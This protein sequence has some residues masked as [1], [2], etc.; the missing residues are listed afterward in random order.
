MAGV[1]VGREV[2]RELCSSLPEANRRKKSSRYGR[3]QSFC[4]KSV[5]FFFD[6]LV[7]ISRITFVLPN[8]KQCSHP[9]LPCLT[10]SDLSPLAA[11][12]VSAKSPQGTSC[13]QEQK[14][15]AT[16]NLLN[17]CESPACCDAR[18]KSSRVHLSMDGFHAFDKQQNASLRLINILKNQLCGLEMA[19]ALASA[20]HH[21]LT[22][23]TQP[24]P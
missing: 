13:H 12:W 24:I 4:Y 9:H 19:I 14:H 10:P 18:V 7:N 21:W 15:G 11:P 3:I 16:K 8:A 1:S 5:V 20:R 17:H 6:P 2:G 23:L 22:Q